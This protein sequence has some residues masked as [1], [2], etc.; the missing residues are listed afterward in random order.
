MCSAATLSLRNFSSENLNSLSLRNF[1]SENLNSAC[2]MP[3]RSKQIA[4]TQTAG[5]EGSTPLSAGAHRERSETSSGSLPAE[6]R[7]K[8]EPLTTDDIP[9]IVKVVVDAL[10]RPA[11]LHESSS[12]SGA[13][14]MNRLPDPLP[15]DAT[16]NPRS[17]DHGEY[18]NFEYT[19]CVRAAVLWSTCTVLAYLCSICVG[20]LYIV[21]HAPF[22]EW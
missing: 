12:S 4:W 22:P 15:T 8:K 2:G 5:E 6:K 1:S 21:T 11:N 20:P 9:H 13:G 3:C 19:L 16:D 14:S 7:R 17:T 10:P 18:C